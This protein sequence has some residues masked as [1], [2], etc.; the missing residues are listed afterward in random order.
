MNNLL[1]LSF[2]ILSG[3]FLSH[4]LAQEQDALEAS[5]WEYGVET[6]LYFHQ[7]FVK[8]KG[9]AIMFCLIC[10]NSCR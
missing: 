10:N 2:G 9:N 3:L 8:G 5:E 7:T 6:D 4:T 1:I